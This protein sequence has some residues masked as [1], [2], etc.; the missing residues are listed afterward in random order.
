MSRRLTR[1]V[2]G[3]GI[4]L[5]LLGWGA[6]Q[7]GKVTLDTLRPNIRAATTAAHSARMPAFSVHL[8]I[9]VRP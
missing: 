1:A 6:G 2:I 8:S 7:V 4:A 5:S 9:E 3:S